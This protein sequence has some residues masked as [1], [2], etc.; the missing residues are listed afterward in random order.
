MRGIIYCFFSMLLFIMGC[1]EVV[2]EDVEILT[3]VHIDLDSSAFQEVYD[4]KDRWER[5]SLAEL[6]SHPDP[7]FRAFAARLFADII[8]PNYII[9]ID[10]LNN[11]IVYEYRTEVDFIL[12]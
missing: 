6:L 9:K 7:S 11:D 1:K 12:C 8:H 10:E 3:D 5:D 2:E 4:F